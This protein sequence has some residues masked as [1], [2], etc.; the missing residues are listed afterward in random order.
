M[1][2]APPRL[3]WSCCLSHVKTVLHLSHVE[4][5]FLHISTISLSEC[6]SPP[7]PTI[8][9]VCSDVS[10]AVSSTYASLAADANPATIAWRRAA[11]ALPADP[12]C[13]TTSWSIMVLSSAEDACAASTS[14]ASTFLR[15][16][17]FAFFDQ[18]L[19][20]TRSCSPSCGV[21]ATSYRHQ[22]RENGSSGA[23]PGTHTHVRPMR[24][25]ASPIL[26]TSAN[27][28]AAPPPSLPSATATGCW[29]TASVSIQTTSSLLGGLMSHM[30]PSQA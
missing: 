26:A 12:N 27:A 15:I 13:F 3:A 29:L 28:T 19:H 22:L 30:E 16:F 4:A 18:T 7:L 9:A 20:P 2:V 14:S 1:T 21:F 5:A 25:T 10:A 11:E 23:S 17:L 8:L 6:V 24:P